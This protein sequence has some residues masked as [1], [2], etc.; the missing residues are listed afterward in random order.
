MKF[1]AF[2]ATVNAW[3]HYQKVKFVFICLTYMIPPVMVYAWS[4]TAATPDFRC[5]TPNG[6]DDTYQETANQRFHH[7]L[8]PTAN[9]CAAHQKLLSLK[10]C[11]RCYRR[12]A[13]SN[14][15]Q[16]QACDGYV[17]DRSVYKRTLVEEVQRSDGGLDRN[18]VRSA[19][20]GPWFAI[21]WGIAQPCR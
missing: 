21:E 5:R 16:L 7:L 15:S 4:F 8:R 1:D 9:E 14:N 10:E 18:E 20:S 17:F 19:C 2:L 6:L 12:V 3:G 11:Q 13:P